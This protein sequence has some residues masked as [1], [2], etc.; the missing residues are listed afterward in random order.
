MGAYEHYLA[1][2]GIKGQKWGIRRYQN[3]DGTL[4]AEGRARYLNPDGSLNELGKKELSRSDRKAVNKDYKRGIAKEYTKT[5][6]KASELEDQS[7]EAWEK[8]SEKYKSLG[9]NW[10]QRIR[11]VTAAQKGN[12]TKEASEYLKLSQEASDK[13]DA[14]YEYWEKAD[15]L[16]KKLGKTKLTRV[17]NAAKYS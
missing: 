11:A 9:K 8:A 16:Y 12:G 15:N 7:D 14:A 4:T 1:H 10:L 17:I 2:H 6:N 3:E 5:Y 13:G